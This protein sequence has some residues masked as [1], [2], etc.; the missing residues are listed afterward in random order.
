MELRFESSRLTNYK[1][2][3]LFAKPFERPTA[4]W[5]QNAIAPERL[6]LSLKPGS[7]A[8]KFQK[9]KTP[10]DSGWLWR[11]PFDPFDP[12]DTFEP[13]SLAQQAQRLPPPRA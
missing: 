3:R 5:I 10:G 12:F 6:N 13:L 9:G 2:R 4:S 7:S 1:H 11:Q 8:A